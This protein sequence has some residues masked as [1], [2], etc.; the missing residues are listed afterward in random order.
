MLTDLRRRF[1]L[2]PGRI[3]LLAAL[4]AFFGA[5]L[6]YPLGYVIVNAF[7]DE[8]G[9]VTGQFIWLLVSDPQKWGIVLN[10]L[11]LGIAVTVL[12]TLLAVPLAYVMTRY[13][14]RGRGILSGLLLVPMVL[15]PFVAAVGMKQMFARFGSINLLLMKLGIIHTPIDWFIGGGMLGVIILEVLHLYPIMYLNVAAAMANVD[16][17]LEEAGRSVGASGFTLFRRITFPLMMPG[18][19]AGATIVF[20]WAF[21]DLGTPLIFEYRQVVPVQIFDKITDISDPMGY[22]L[23][24]LLIVMTVA[25]FL[26]TKSVV[27]SKRYEMLARGHVASGA[28]PASRKMA[29]GIY[30]GL[31]ALTA[32]ALIPHISVLLMSFTDRWFLTVLPGS[33]TFKHYADVFQ[34]EV[35]GPSIVNSLFLSGAS[36]FVDILLGIGIAYLLARTR[37]PGRNVIDALTMLPLAVPG[38]IIAFG[39]LTGFSNTF[40]NARAN[41]FPL[42][43]IGYSVRRLPYMVRTAYAGFQQT[44]VT[45]EEAAHN[46]GAGPMRTLWRITMPL[47]FAN[48]VAGG[49]LCFTFAMLEVSDGLILAFEP[50][51]YP[52]TK[53]IY[54]LSSR[55]PDGPY[56]A[57]AMGII[58]MLLLAAGLIIVGR[59]L[60]KRMGELFRV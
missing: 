25:F 7:H 39:Y 52:I 16:P 27:G 8:N 12:T 31:L 50:K 23:V 47:V 17:G 24:L 38:V 49:I 32:V 45:L 36:T 51:F 14:F 5:F 40:L 11:N 57:S 60:G 20:I 46:V 3:A 28:K 42:L 15:P 35:T 4:A 21:T 56:I 22:A 30:V 43:I 48:L 37:I 33:Y 53:A 10:S 19:F 54:D 26:L 1:D 55:L 18:Y 29:A 13:T 59:F 41:P 6:V 9:H 2:T 44:S 58:G 34:H